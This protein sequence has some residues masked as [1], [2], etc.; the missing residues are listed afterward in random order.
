MMLFCED[1]PSMHVSHVPKDPSDKSSTTESS[2][3]IE[4][5]ILVKV[6]IICT[7]LERKC[8]LHLFPNIIY[9]IDDIWEQYFNG[10]VT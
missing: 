10:I 8:P 9:S 2:E 1:L 5:K 6:E 4:L 3:S 7:Y